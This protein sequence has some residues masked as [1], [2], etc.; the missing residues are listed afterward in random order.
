MCVCLCT[1]DD[2]TQVYAKRQRLLQASQLEEERTQRLCGVVSKAAQALALVSILAENNLGRMALSL[3][4][5][6]RQ[7]LLR[8]V[9][10]HAR[11]HTHTRTHEGT[12][13]QVRRCALDR[14]I[15]YK[16]RRYDDH[17][18]YKVMVDDKLCV[19]VCCRRCVI[20]CVRVRVRCWPPHS[21]V[22]W[23]HN[24]WMRQWREATQVGP[25]RGAHHVAATHTQTDTRTHAHR[26]AHTRARAP[27]THNISSEHTEPASGARKTIARALAR[28]MRTQAHTVMHEWCDACC[29]W[30]VLALLSSSQVLVP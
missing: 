24:T 16:A 10:D 22:C 23:S 26:H 9:R 4:E 14:L 2:P 13:S 8:L 29:E 1:Q 30:C 27:R 21:S 18:I 28:T 17:Q 11:A 6:A 7:Q 12:S 20:L 3:P 5:T 15:A 19:F 25:V